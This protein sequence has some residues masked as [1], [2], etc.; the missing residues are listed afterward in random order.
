MHTAVKPSIELE[1]ASTPALGLHAQEAGADALVRLPDQGSFRRIWHVFM[2]ARIA[3]AS[4]LVGLQIVI[5]FMGGGSSALTVGVCG[6]YMAAT[7]AVRGCGRPRP[8]R[9]DFDMQWLLTIGVDVLAFSMLEFQQAAGINYA[10]LFALPVLLASVLGPILLAFG[11]AATVTVLL[12]AHAWANSLLGAA[13]FNPRLLQAG[14]SGSGFFLVALLANQ[15]ASRLAQQELRTRVSQGAARMQALVS[16]MVVQTLAEGVMVADASGVVRSSNPAGR[17]LLGLSELHHH[18]AFML[19]ADPEWSPLAL[20]MRQTFSTQSAQQSDVTLQ[21]PGA[22]AKQLRVRTR[23]AL[24][25]GRMQ[26]NLCVIFI[27]DLR[28]MQAKVRTEK[29]AAMGRMSAAVA[30][31]IRNPL[32][33]ISQANAL[34]EEDLCDASH[35]QLTT[36]MRQ[37]VQRLDKIVDEILN[38][39]RVQEQLTS[40]V[41]SSLPLDATAARI[42]ADWAAQHMTG[43]R[44]HLALNA[45]QAVVWFD[46]D[47]LRRV[48]INLLDNAARYASASAG[49]IQLCTTLSAGQVR[50]SVWSD[51]AALENS[52]QAHLFEPFFSSESRSSGLGLY[53]CRELCERYGAQLHYARAVY[54][55]TSGNDFFVLFRPTPAA[56]T[57]ALLLASVY[58][59]C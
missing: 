56:S 2:T 32:A 27:E 51:G 9:S 24:S 6:A 48:L 23:L 29:M 26:D 49:A 19:A 42:A 31:E 43:Q 25:E 11:T 54:S 4:V 36:I 13:D 52:V 55:G 30:H 38:V 39:S 17:R 59:I 8:Q 7:V 5:F 50:L 10:P 47:H 53:I 14:L 58:A 16:D 33:A 41:M 3:I 1:Q 15:L 57:D 21:A 28:E 37:N 44:L 22:P 46:E 20:L 34:L 40:P 18:T 45:L 12:L 35:R